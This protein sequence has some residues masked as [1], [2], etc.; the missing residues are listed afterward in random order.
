LDGL[1]PA[2]TVRNR[3]ILVRH[4][5]SQDSRRASVRAVTPRGG[6]SN[7]RAACRQ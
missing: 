1:D 6:D 7:H 3:V 4:G 2:H 5:Y